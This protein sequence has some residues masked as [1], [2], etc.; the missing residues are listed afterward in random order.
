MPLRSSARLTLSSGLL[1]R[2]ACTHDRTDGVATGTPAS[3]VISS[4]IAWPAALAKSMNRLSPVRT[5]YALSSTTTVY[6]VLAATLPA[7]RMVLTCGWLAV[8]ACVAL[9][10]AEATASTD[11]TAACATVNGRFTT[12]ACSSRRRASVSTEPTVSTSSVLL[13][14]AVMATDSA[15]LRTHSTPSATSTLN[16]GLPPDCSAASSVATP[17]ARSLAS[18][19]SSPAATSYNTWRPSTVTV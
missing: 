18:C 10:P 2:T 19:P 6:S 4:V 16:T 5:V 17:R 12:S 9:R 8:A 15:P 7:K 1:T 13:L 11:V 3:S 14:M